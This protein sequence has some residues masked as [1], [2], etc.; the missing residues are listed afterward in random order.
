M[1]PFLLVALLAF[2]TQVYAQE[3]IPVGTVLPLRLESALSSKST[4][5]QPIKARVMQDVPLGQ[6]SKIPAGAKVMG[7]VVKVTPNSKGA[8]AE[9]SFKFDRVVFSHHAVPV[10]SDLRAMA[11]MAEIDDALVPDMGPDRGTPPSAYTTVQVGGDE[12]VYRGGGHVMDAS[13]IAGEPAPDGILARVRPNS[14]EGCRGELDPSQPAQQAFWV[15][16]SD[17]C[18]VYGLANVKIV[19]SGRGNPAGQIVLASERG[20][21]S[22]PGGSGLLLRVIGNRPNVRETR[23]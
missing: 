6:G 20:N 12:V 8:G 2:S 5:G 1:K 10:T 15:F 7:N 11:S 19:N 14:I 21:L 23:N 18:G 13:E 9:I 17:V 22:I 16:S 3:S 4:P